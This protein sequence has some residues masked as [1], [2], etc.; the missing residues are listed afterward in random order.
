MGAVA[1]F[2]EEAAGAAR[3]MSNSLTAPKKKNDEFGYHD[4]DGRL[5]SELR[6][7]LSKPLDGSDVTSILDA[8]RQLQ[9]LRFA[10][11]CSSNPIH[12]VQDLESG[13]IEV[14]DILVPPMVTVANPDVEPTG[15]FAKALNVIGLSAHE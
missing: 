3:R 8:K 10:L 15:D 9:H 1:S 7:Q 4:P 13:T 12:V 14:R 2:P 6:Y 11:F 5:L